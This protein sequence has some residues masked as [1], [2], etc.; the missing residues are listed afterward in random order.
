MNDIISA[1]N[2]VIFKYLFGRNKEI[3]KAFISAML[4]IPQEDMTGLTIL[5]PEITPDAED[6]KLSRLDI[7]LETTDRKINI[8]MQNVR[9]EDYRERV[10]Y[11]WA[12]M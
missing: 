2:D 5:N 1:K 10:L 3:L 12:K 9:L 6:G 7:F 8:E 4:N 11:Y